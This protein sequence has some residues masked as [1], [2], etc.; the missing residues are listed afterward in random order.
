MAAQIYRVVHHFG[1]S[2]KAKR[3]SKKMIK[4]FFFFFF[5]L[6]P[7]LSAFCDFSSFFGH[8]TGSRQLS[9]NILLCSLLFETSSLPQ[10]IDI[11]I[12]NIEIPKRCVRP[13]NTKRNKSIPTRRH[14]LPTWIIQSVFSCSG[15][16]L[17]SKIFPSREKWEGSWERGQN[18]VDD[19]IIGIDFEW[20][21]FDFCQR[22]SFLL[23][24]QSAVRTELSII[25]SNHN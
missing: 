19:T 22:Q 7:V 4:C 11:E 2:R 9:R 14:I 23:F 13:L 1:E 25:T 16:T 8:S 24:V 12:N 21:S 17:K 15:S 6:E 20:I 18:S 3:K 10:S 5:L